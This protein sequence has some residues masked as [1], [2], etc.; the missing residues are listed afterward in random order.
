[1]GPPIGSGNQGIILW[2]NGSEWT[3]FGNSLGPG[4]A[5]QVATWNGTTW[6][7]ATPAGGNI[8]VTQNTLTA[9]VGLP[10]NSPHAVCAIGVTAGHTYLMGFNVTFNIPTNV[11]TL[12]FSAF[13]T[14]NV[15]SDSNVGGTM[16]ALATSGSNYYGTMAATK[17]YTVVS[18]SSQI[19]L[20]VQAIT[21]SGVVIKSNNATG[22]AGATNLWAMQLS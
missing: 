6:I 8:P 7:T 16:T 11:V 12:P 3:Y 18:G 17:I 2:W 15:S 20:L 4:N 5:G 14:D 10:D 13:L 21:G 19:Q 22:A 1:M 9:D